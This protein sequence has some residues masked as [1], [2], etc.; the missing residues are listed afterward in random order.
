MNECHTH[1][2]THAFTW[3]YLNSPIAKEM[4]LKSQ[5]LRV[6]LNF[7]FESTALIYGDYPPIFRN[8]ITDTRKSFGIPCFCWFVLFSLAYVFFPMF[9]G[10]CRKTGVIPASPAHW[11]LTCFQFNVHPTL[12]TTFKA[13]L[14]FTQR[15]YHVKMWH[16]C[17]LCITQ[18]H[19]CKQLKITT[20]TSL[21]LHLWCVSRV[22]PSFE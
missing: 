1:T 3:E 21:L 2:D 15:C 5:M 18:K 7:L 11:P 22:S 12:F 10:L 19:R 9:L 8:S 17:K 14:F 4:T 6:K 20:V 16:Q 13:T